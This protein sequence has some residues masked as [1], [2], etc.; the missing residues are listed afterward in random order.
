MTQNKLTI[1]I[2][3][4]E[5]DIA[6]LPFLLNSLSII[7]NI[8]F[9]VIIGLSRRIRTVEQFTNFIP[10]LQYNI[11]AI[12]LGNTN[13][14]PFIGRKEIAFASNC[15]YIWFLDADDVVK[16]EPI[17]KD[18][19][20]ISYNTPSYVSSP[21]IYE[22]YCWMI[23]KGMALWSHI[24]KTD[25]VR[26]AY[27]YLP[28]SYDSMIH[29]DTFLILTCLKLCK[30]DYYVIPQTVVTY[31][32]SENLS[33]TT[34]SYRDTLRSIDY[35]IDQWNYWCKRLFGF[36]MN[37]SSWY[38]IRKIR[39][40]CNTYKEFV[41][42][43]NKYGIEENQIPSFEKNVDATRTYWIKDEEGTYKEVDYLEYTKH[44]SSRET[45]S[46][47]STVIYDTDISED[48]RCKKMKEMYSV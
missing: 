8:E 26:R 24:I 33:V 32:E 13:P 29:E 1:G 18:Y 44:L 45:S 47:P 34:D 42:T 41:E 39:S 17:I 37:F 36:N 23:N 12:D 15:P 38:V 21:N 43:C 28:S 11:R 20:I 9:E 2:I 5:N 27:S 19:S 3:T 30:F 7:K 4:S 31:K 40:F 22:S 35:Q 46:P 14:G 16:E 48:N 6:K 25:I 10:N